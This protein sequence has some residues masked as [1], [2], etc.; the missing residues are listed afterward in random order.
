MRFATGMTRAADTAPQVQPRQV[1][2]NLAICSDV[3][4][5]SVP[6]DFLPNGTMFSNGVPTPT[7]GVQKVFILEEKP[8]LSLRHAMEMLDRK[9]GQEIHL[10]WNPTVQSDFNTGILPIVDIAPQ[11]V[12]NVRPDRV[13]LVV[14]SNEVPSSSPLRSPEHI[15]AALTS[16]HSFPFLL[17]PDEYR[18]MVN[19]LNQ[20]SHDRD[21][22]TREVEMLTARLK[23]E[24]KDHRSATELLH[25]IKEFQAEIDELKI[26]NEALS[27]E[28]VE[29]QRSAL[30]DS[31]RRADRFNAKRLVKRIIAS[32]SPR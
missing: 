29:I 19:E 28:L 30:A 14:S 24:S 23:S 20:L 10:I 18:L 27:N 17:A 15:R 9:E 16:I 13:D 21:T 26:R 32:V 1:S 25:L 3:T 31:F 5:L 2:E 11:K 8:H 7:S 22:L 6:A 4:S 12:L